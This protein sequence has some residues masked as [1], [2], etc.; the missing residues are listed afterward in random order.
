MSADLENLE[1]LSLVSK[2]VTELDNHFGI[3][4]VNVAKVIIEFA[5]ENPTFDRFKRVL[6]ENELEDV[7]F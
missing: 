3:N 4:D 1:Y 6:M 7:S 5:L 2:V